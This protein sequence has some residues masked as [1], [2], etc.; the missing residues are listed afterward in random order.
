[1]AGRRD[2][3]PGDAGAQAGLTRRL[4]LGSAAALSPGAALAQPASTKPVIAEIPIEM[5]PTPWTGVWIEGKGPF[6]FSI[7][8][9][10][11]GFD[12]WDGLAEKLGLKLR[13]TENIRRRG[14]DRRPIDLYLADKIVIGGALGLTF[15]EFGSFHTEKPP[16]SMGIIPL[17][18][19]RVTTF[20]WDKRVMRFSADMPADLSGYLRVPLVYEEQFLGWQPEVKCKIGGRDV[21]LEIST[22]SGNGIL[23]NSAAVSRLK[24]WDDPAAAYDRMGGDQRWRVSRRGD[25]ELGAVRFANPIVWLEDPRTSRYREDDYD[26]TIGMDLLR[27][28]DLVFDQ[29]KRVMWFRPLPNLADPW[30]HDRAGFDLDEKDGVWRF[31][32]VDPGSPAERAGLKAGDVLVAART[33]TGRKLNGAVEAPAGTKLAFSVTRGAE[34]QRISITL[35]DRL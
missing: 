34:T 27:R 25:L 26:G 6:R 19:D 12:I 28:G 20:D 2:H 24:L 22:G 8:T 32:A 4:V 30:K 15:V 7:V 14:N 33:D 18:S 17:F 9:G 21:R 3:R 1:L 35:E 10:T 29:K 16:S 5:D 23:L 13:R 31:T 11:N